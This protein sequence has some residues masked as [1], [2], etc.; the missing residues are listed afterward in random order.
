MTVISH[1]LWTRLLSSDPN[2]LGRTLRIEDVPFTIV[3]VASSEF[4]GTGE[5]AQDLWLPLSALGFL[6]G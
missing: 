3:G 2:V 1:R 6:P 5:A 4:G